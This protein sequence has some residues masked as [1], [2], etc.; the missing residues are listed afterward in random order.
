[1]TQECGES[2]PV[3]IVAQFPVV[4]FPA[5]HRNILYSLEQHAVRLQLELVPTEN[6]ML[7]ISLTGKPPEAQIFLIC[8]PLIGG[9]CTFNW[10]MG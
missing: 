1:M 8:L 9:S 3:P 2:Q 5:Y 6:W 4:L 7:A 10:K